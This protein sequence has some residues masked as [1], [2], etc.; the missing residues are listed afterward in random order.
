M[1]TRAWKRRQEAIAAEA[2]LLRAKEEQSKPQPE[3]AKMPPGFREAL[4]EKGRLEKWLQTL[5]K[6]P[7]VVSIDL[8]DNKWIY[9]VRG[10][11]CP[12]EYWN[13]TPIRHITGGSSN[14]W[15]QTKSLS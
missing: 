14:V 11:Q 2:N 6:R 12:L 10:I 9:T 1:S 7:V 4:E 15:T 3:K 8:L 5:Q 13:D